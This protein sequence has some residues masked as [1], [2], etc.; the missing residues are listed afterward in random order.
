MSDGAR[1]QPEDGRPPA[2]EA[3][4]S[5]RLQRLGERLDQAKTSRSPGIDQASRRSDNASGFALG[6]RLSSELVG[7]VII[8]AAL[9]WLIDRWAGTSPWGLIVLLLLGFAAGV[10][11]VVRSVNRG[12]PMDDRG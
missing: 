5:A 2:D 8:G 4:L 12:T 10:H 11:S 9:G 1:E 3:A 6:L 7:A